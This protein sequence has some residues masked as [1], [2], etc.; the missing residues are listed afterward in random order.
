MGREEI[1]L[2][3]Y[4]LCEEDNNASSSNYWTTVGIF[5]GVNTALISAIGAGIIAGF[6]NPRWPSLVLV[7]A[8]GV[9]AIA[10]VIIMHLWLYRVNHLIGV[11]HY[12]MREIENELGMMRGTLVWML[13][14]WDTVDNI[15]FKRRLVNTWILKDSETVDEVI[16]RKKKDLPKR[17]GRLRQ[18]Y[19]LCLHFFG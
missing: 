8:F 5:I 14:H 7:I 17:Y 12:R 6:I 1:L 16:K 4:E 11:N 2:K 19:K 9:I 18:E 3:E 13:D 15:E 10:L